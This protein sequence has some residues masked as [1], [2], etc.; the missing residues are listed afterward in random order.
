MTECPTCGGE[1]YDNREKV[2]GG[3]KGPVFK[4]RDAACGW[5][6]WPPKG[7]KAAPARG[8]KWTWST[9]SR[10]YARCLLLAEKH[11]GEPSKRTKKDFTM[12]DVLA[13]TATLLIAADRGGMQE[14]M[15]KA[16]AEPLDQPPRALAAVAA[17]DDDL[18]F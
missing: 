13:S 8:P 11:V 17:D 10:T 9:L 16:A 3:W 1:L 5:V 12:A 2:A 18:P 6:K 14:A 4:C 15:P 7:A